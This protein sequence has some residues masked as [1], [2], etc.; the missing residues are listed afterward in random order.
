MRDTKITGFCVALVKLA[1]RLVL[2]SYEPGNFTR[3]GGQMI[4]KN[5]F[6]DIHRPPFY[7]YELNRSLFVI[8]RGSVVPEDYLTDAEMMELD[9]EFGV[10]HTGFYNASCYVYE[11]VEPFV[12]R[13]GGPVYFTGHSYG[14]SVADILLVMMRTRH[15]EVDSNAIGYAPMPAVSTE[16]SHTHWDRIAS[17]RNDADLVPTLS[18]PNIYQTL[19]VLGP[20]IRIANREWIINT[21]NGLVSIL[22]YTVGIL[23][24]AV[25]ETIKRDVPLLVDDIQGYA[26]GEVRVIRYPPGVV[27]EIGRS[28]GMRLED[29]VIDAE[30]ELDR[31]I[32]TPWGCA[33]HDYPKYEEAVE[34]I[35]DDV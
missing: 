20:F 32:I 16:V 33:E 14:A 12:A 27:Y 2:C 10:L 35:P 3:M 5:E 24:K 8:V 11:Q 31:L 34:K 4:Y 23:S 1:M 19:W 22:E 29:C 15:P 9:T 25:Y 13:F 21:L 17:F 26:R 18:I 28:E 30:K 6:C 7:V